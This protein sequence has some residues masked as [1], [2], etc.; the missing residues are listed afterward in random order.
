MRTII[1]IAAAITLVAAS[2]DGPAFQPSIVGAVRDSGAAW[3]AGHNA[4]FDGW[5]LKQAKGLCGALKG[6]PILPVKTYPDFQYGGIPTSFDSRVQWGKECPSTLEIRDQAACGSCWAFGAAEA[7]TD[8]TCIASNGTVTIDLSAEDILSCC[9][10]WCGSGCEGGY[11]ASAWS[12]WNTNGV[13]T[14]GLYKGTGCY[15]YEI[16]GCDHHVNGTLKP[17][18]NIVPTP[19][20]TS[21]CVNGAVWANDKHFG[22]SNYQVNSVQDI[23]LE[24]MNHGPVEAAFTV[25]EDFLAYKSGVYHHVTGAELGGHAIKILGWGV[26]SGT[27][28][29]IVANSWN[30]DWG[31][32]G[33]FNIKKGTDECGIEDGVVAGI[34]K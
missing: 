8:R 33:Y 12:Y 30:V 22:A 16:P 26:E 10:F 18:G 7:I 32:K 31:N 29:W 14:G 34:P 21:E 15:P 2:M 19:A 24:I 3:V 28:Y 20:C 25:Y 6:G 5:T 17:C 27:D 23:Q 11:P 4:H 9:G 13:V 1:L